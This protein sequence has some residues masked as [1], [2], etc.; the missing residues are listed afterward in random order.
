M[1]SKQKNPFSDYE[2][3]KAYH[4]ERRECSAAYDVHLSTSITTNVRPDRVTIRM[5]AE[6]VDPPIPGRPLLCSYT[7]QWPNMEGSSFSGALF[8]ASVMMTR[9]VQDSVADLWRDTLRAHNRG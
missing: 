9:L 8:R 3:L 7:A 5:E 1:P 2:M 6:L 4:T